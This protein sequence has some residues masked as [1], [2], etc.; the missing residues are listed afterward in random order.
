MK[1]SV[2]AVL[3]IAALAF[4]RA[5]TPACVLSCVNTTSASATGISAAAS[6]TWCIDCCLNVLRRMDLGGGQCILRTHH[7]S[8][9]LLV[10]R[11]FE[12]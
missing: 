2:F 8:S 4:V 10:L 3:S 7:I 5:E 1:A 6:S 11:T 12:K 9:L